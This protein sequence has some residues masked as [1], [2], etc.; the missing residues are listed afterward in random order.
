M[1]AF[2]ITNEA[3]RVVG[4]VRI[5]DPETRDTPRAGRPVPSAGH[6]VHEVQLTPDMLKIKTASELHRALEA[7]LAQ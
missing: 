3:G 5:I 7:K 6:R 4:H 1:K 2:V